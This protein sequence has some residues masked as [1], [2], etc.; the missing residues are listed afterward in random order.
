MSKKDFINSQNAIA[1]IFNKHRNRPPSFFGGKKKK[2]HKLSYYG[3]LAFIQGTL[4][5]KLSYKERK[6]VYKYSK[7]NKFSSNVNYKTY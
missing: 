7:N 6:K 2:D 4:K 5:R 3:H 1:R